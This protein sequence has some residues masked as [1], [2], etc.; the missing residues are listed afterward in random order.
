MIDT[1]GVRSFGLAHVGPADLLWAF[2][3]LEGGAVTCPR[4]CAHLSAA[5][6]CALDAWTA[7]GHAVAERLAAFRRL[8]DEPRARG[9]PARCGTLSR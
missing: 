2:P 9:R 8:A 4:G 6:G 5:D 1:P 3:D 7:D